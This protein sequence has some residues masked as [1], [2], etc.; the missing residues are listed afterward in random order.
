MKIA[1]STL[2]IFMLTLSTY[3]QTLNNEIAITGEQPFLLGKIDKSGLEGENYKSWFSKNYDAYNPNKVTTVDMASELKNYDIK[4]FM[5]TWCGDS[6]REVP[7]L[8]KVLEASNFPMDQL[9]AVAVSR[10][11]DMYKQS[12]QHEEAG[13]NIHRVPTIIFYKDGKEVNRIVEHPVESFEADIKSII[14]NNAYTSNYHFVTTVDNIIKSSGIKGF[15]KNKRSLYKS[16]KGQLKSMYELNTYAHILFTTN[17]KKEAIEVLRFNTKLFPEEPRAFASL[18]RKL[19]V[20]GDT[21]KALKSYKKALK[22]DPDNKDIKKN[23]VALK[24]N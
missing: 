17:R 13:L 21:K 10:K 8:Y 22:L 19:Y 12:P 24:T 18:G 14:T 3:S 20:N 23:I 11:P 7:K 4:L 9:A 6:K 5:G 15:K 1:I 16:H 2:F